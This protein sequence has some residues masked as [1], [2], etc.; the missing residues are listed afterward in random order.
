[1]FTA[2]V[3]AYGLVDWPSERVDAYAD[4]AGVVAVGFLPAL[5]LG[6]LLVARRCSKGTGAG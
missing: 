3:Q 5:W 1:M 6:C 4:V 2:R